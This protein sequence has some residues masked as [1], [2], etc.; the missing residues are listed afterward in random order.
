MKIITN[1][2]E[3]RRRQQLEHDDASDELELE[4]LS[5]RIPKLI[6]VLPD[7]M[8]ERPGGGEK[9]SAALSVML[10]KLLD[11]M[12]PLR[13]VCENEKKKVTLCCCI[14]DE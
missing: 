4:T 12:D 10:A 1:V 5:S 9:S 13:P 2:P 14:A 3:L 7:V 11:C 6:G 8:R